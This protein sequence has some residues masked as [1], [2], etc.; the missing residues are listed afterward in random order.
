M[1]DHRDIAQRLPAAFHLGTSSWT[2][3]GWQGLFYRRDYANAQHFR[4][5]SLEEYAAHPLM[6]TVGIDRSYYQPITADE[7]QLYAKQ[8]PPGF[9]CVL[10]MWQQ[11]STMVFPQHRRYGALAGQSN[12][13]FL[14][15]ARFVETIAT[16]LRQ[17]FLSHSAALVI[18]VSRIPGPI[19]ADAFVEQL[20]QFLRHAP[21][22]FHYAIELRDPRLLTTAYR[23]L[24]QHSGATHVYNFWSQMP[25]LKRQLEHISIPQN[26]KTILRLLLPPG[27][28]YEKRRRQLEPFQ[29][30]QEPQTQ[31]RDDVRTIA[32]EVLAQQGQLFILVGNKSEGCAPLTVE[33]L[34]AQLAQL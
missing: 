6:R 5:H 30:L 27:S 9:P 16:P 23:Q 2:F 13:D 34:G 22:E 17:S 20:H 31:M 3:P 33:A 25:S 10:K 1:G 29:H 19:N 15:V 32:N 24:L 12:P 28:D 26:S 21:Q 4:R 14:N 18:E 8:L 7:L 11:L